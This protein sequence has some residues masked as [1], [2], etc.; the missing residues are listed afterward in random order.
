MH[1]EGVSTKKAVIFMGFG[2]ESGPILETVYPQRQSIFRINKPPADF[3]EV[4]LTGVQE[5]A[6][7]SGKEVKLSW[8]S[9][10][11]NVE[12]FEIQLSSDEGAHFQ[13]VGGVS[14][15]EFTWPVPDQHSGTAT[16]RIIAHR[17]DGTSVESL[18]GPALK[19]K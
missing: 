3:E 17:S 4:M 1:A 13:T 2:C 16:F 10:I 18:I 14:G 12:H 5:S 7:D 9:T 6:G 11:R 8:N 19:L 15:Q